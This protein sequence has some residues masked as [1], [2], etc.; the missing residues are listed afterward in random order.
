MQRRNIL[1]ITLCHLL[2]CLSLAVLVFGCIIGEKSGNSTVIIFSVILFAVALAAIVYIDYSLGKYE[3]KACG[4]KFSPSFSEYFF[5]PH[6]FSKRKL[7]CPE[8]GEKGYF[9]RN[10]E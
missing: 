2:I 5:A 3:C 1:K 7:K 4:R 6:I 9:K 8:C 10:I